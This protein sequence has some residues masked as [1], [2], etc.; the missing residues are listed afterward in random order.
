MSFIRWAFRW[1]TILG[2]YVAAFTYVLYRV[3]GDRKFWR[4]YL[5]GARQ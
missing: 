1:L 5:G 4:Y 3:L 2:T